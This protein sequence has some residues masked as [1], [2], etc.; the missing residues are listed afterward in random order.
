MSTGA[1][2]LTSSEVELQDPASTSR[3]DSIHASVLTQSEHPT[4]SMSAAD[5]TAVLFAKYLSYDFE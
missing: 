2:S 5:L 1:I 4:S 3:V